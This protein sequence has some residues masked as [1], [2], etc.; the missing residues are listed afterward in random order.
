MRVIAGSARRLKLA[1]PY[2][3]DTRPTQDIIK[4][5]MINIIQDD[6]PGYVFLVLCAGSG[7]IGIEYLSMGDLKDC[8]GTN[9]D[10]GST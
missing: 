7:A 4:E 3:L 5:T 10:V 2:G 9:G 6:V 8:F 1:A